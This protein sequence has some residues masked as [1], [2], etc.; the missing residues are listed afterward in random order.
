MIS[1]QPLPVIVR[2]PTE[3][4][5]K[6]KRMTIAIGAPFQYDNMKCALVCA[7]S[8]IV[9]SDGST[10]WG[11]KMHLSIGFDEGK[12]ISCS[13][14]ASASEDANAALMLAK[15]ITSAISDKSIANTLLVESAVKAKMTD[16]QYAY[17]YRQPPPTEFVLAVAV[18]GCCEILFCSPPNTVISKWEPFAIGSGSR[19][20]IPLLPLV[21][22]ILPSA[23]SAALQAAYWIYRAK[24]DEGSACGG[25]M[26]LVMVSERGTFALFDQ[27]DGLKAADAL[28]ERVDELLQQCRYGLLSWHE[29]ETQAQFISKFSSDY[30][31]L[32]KEAHE[33]AFPSLEWLKGLDK[34]KPLKPKQS[35]TQKL[36]GQQ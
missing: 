32:A 34:L 19:A 9:W 27:D 12:A 20:V 8:R 4:L 3:R 29:T 30:L 36:K 16:W 13:A 14:I 21:T 7:D 22:S 17:G 31:A 18:G 15:E 5:P 25:N 35:G 11:S 10:A 1:A 24:R 2:R 23:E 28:G 6:R 26:N 33:I